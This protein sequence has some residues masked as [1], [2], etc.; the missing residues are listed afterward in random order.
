MCLGDIKNQSRQLKH[1]DLRD[2]TKKGKGVRT[3]P[4]GRG[5]LWQAWRGADGK[6]HMQGPLEA[7]LVKC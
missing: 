3:Q 1:E 2:T 6:E 5:H 7:G 4:G